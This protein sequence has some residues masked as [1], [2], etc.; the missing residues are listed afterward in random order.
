MNYGIVSGSFVFDGLRAHADEAFDVE[1][2]GAVGFED[3]FAA[4]AVGKRVF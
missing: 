1:A 4:G 3:D 2:R